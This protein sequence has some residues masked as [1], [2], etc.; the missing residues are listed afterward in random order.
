MEHY[1]GNEPLNIG[2][3]TDQTIR[4]LADLVRGIVGYQGEIVFDTNKPDGAPQKL[5][6]S[7]RLSAM[8]WRPQTVLE[9]GVA[10][11]YGWYLESL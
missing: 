3:G 11:A 4:E 9:E 5:L 8:G 1:S 2:L 7:S 10:K 6:D